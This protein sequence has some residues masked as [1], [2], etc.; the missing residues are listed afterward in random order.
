MDQVLFHS[1]IKNLYMISSGMTN[2]FIFSIGPSA[3]FKDQWVAYDNSKSIV[4]KGQYILQNGFGGASA[5][6]VDLDDFTNRCCKEPFPLLRSL[7][8][9]IGRLKISSKD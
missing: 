7:N 3:Y 5:W 2:N 6:T 9:A 4:E 8:R 1:R